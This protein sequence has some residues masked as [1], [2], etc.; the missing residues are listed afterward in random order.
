MVM[1]I[2]KNLG[3]SQSSRNIGLLGG[4]NWDTGTWAGEWEKLMWLMAGVPEDDPP[5]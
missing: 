4:C 1:A 5:I 2:R 3:R